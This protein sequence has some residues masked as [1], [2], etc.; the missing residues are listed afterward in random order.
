MDLA[1]VSDILGHST[2]S[3][4]VS[5]YGH[6]TEQHKAAAMRQFRERMALGSKG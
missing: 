3:T 1:T 6:L 5:I 2:I 4:T